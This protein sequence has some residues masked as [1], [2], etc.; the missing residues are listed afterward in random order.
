MDSSSLLYPSGS[1]MV[2]ELSTPCNG[3]KELNEVMAEINEVLTFQLH[4][5]DSEEEVLQSPQQ[6][7]VPFNSM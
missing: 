6:D 2:A 3:F 4:V 5:M 1:E 7:S